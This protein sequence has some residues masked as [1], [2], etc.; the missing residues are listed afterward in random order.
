MLAKKRI[1][2]LL[3][4]EVR[5]TKPAIRLTSDDDAEALIVHCKIVHFCSDATPLRHSID[6][7]EKLA[8]LAEK[9]RCFEALRFA[10]AALLQGAVDALPT[11]FVIL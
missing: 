11:G 7:I 6:C 4:T 9:Y 2:S 1:G 10:S 8:F 5:P 3:N